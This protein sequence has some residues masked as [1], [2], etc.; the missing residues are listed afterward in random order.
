M[1]GLDWPAILLGA[2]LAFGLGMVWFSPLMFGRTWSKGSHGITP[3]DSP[4]MLAMA[5]MVLGTVLLAVVIGMT[6]AIEA[7]G[8]ALLI[9]AAAAVIQ[10]A[11]A[12]FS[13]KTMAAA[14][15]DAG[16]ILAMGALMIAAQAVL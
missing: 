15:V 7:L 6:A 9:L 8:L 2:A 16:Y 13:Q 5:L 11:M 12:L 10:L 1:S 4:P 14:L 3:P